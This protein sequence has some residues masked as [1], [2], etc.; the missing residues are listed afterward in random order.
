V[1][2]RR[3]VLSYANVA[4]TLALVLSFSGGA[5]AATR[6]LINSTSQINPKVLKQLRAARGPEG[7]AGPAGS[8]GKPGKEGLPGLEGKAG[9]EGKVGA[10]GRRGVE[11]KTGQEGKRGREGP[12]GKEGPPGQEG[13]SGGEPAGLKRWRKTIKT[14]GASEAEAATVVLAEVP[15]LTISGH[16]YEEHGATIAQTY[17]ASTE[18]ESFLRIAKEAKTLTFAG[19]R[20]LTV[21]AAEGITVDNEAA[22]AGGPEG[23]FSA[24]AHDGS[25]ALDGTADQGVWLQGEIGPACSFSGYAIV[26]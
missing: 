26:D 21:Q 24:T 8:E 14:A 9:V 1:R 22:L 25:V 20:P 13:G 11:G 3:R 5:L 17:I 23:S 7:V 2:P 18:T 4:A 12:E 15:P 16:C 19:E 6:Y 10:E